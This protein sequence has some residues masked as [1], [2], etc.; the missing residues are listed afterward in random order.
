MLLALV[1]PTAGEGRLLG[2]PLGDHRTRA[3]VGFL[4]EHFRFHDWLTAPEFLALHADLYRLERSLLGRRIPELID[5]VGLGGQEGK[6][7]RHFSKGMLQRIGL[8]Q[9]LLADPE[10]VFLDEPNSGLDPVGCLLVREII[11]DLSRRGTTVFLNS[12]RLSE[13]EITCDRVAFVNQGVVVRTGSLASLADGELA[14][15]G[16]VKNL[17]PEAAAGLA[18]FGRDV[19]VDGERLRMAVSSEDDIP[20]I[21]RYLVAE[22]ADVYSLSAKHLSL[23]ELFIEIVGPRESDGGTR[24]RGTPGGGGGT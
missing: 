6:R 12:H 3:R 16:R 15:E 19:K 23:E 18:R 22:R 24:G 4:P 9:A 17:R 2:R 11:R 5:L 21:H 13:V 7:L 8:A 20:E 10:I 14:I 1:S